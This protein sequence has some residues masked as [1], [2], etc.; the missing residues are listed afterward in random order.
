MHPCSLN[1]P[2]KI[3]LRRLQFF[4]V[5][6][7]VL[8]CAMAG[9]AA[10]GC[11]IVTPLAPDVDAEPT[12]SIAHVAPALPKALDDEDRRRALGA[13]ALAL[14]PQGNGATVRWDNPVSE[15]HGLVTPL[16][17]AYPAKELVCRQFSAK[18][19]TRAGN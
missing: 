7:A 17:Y 3:T 19:E 11:S 18:F 14:D 9:L 5:A 6:R 16:G 10:S 15:A 12:G 2:S 13:L 1:L 8:V 4:A